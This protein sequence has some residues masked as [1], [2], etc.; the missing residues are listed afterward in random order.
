MQNQLNTYCGS[1]PYAA[2]ELFRD[3]NYIGVYVD[4]WALGVLLF[5]MITGS[6]PFRADTVGKLKR[7]IINGDFVMPGHVSNPCQLLIRGVL[8]LRPLERFSIKEII[9]S[10]W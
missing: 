1:P 10:A 5:F 3:D 7:I 2:P 8:K 4:I 9:D 6:M